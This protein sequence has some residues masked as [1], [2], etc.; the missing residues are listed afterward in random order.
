VGRRKKNAED[1]AGY[2][3]ESL[4]KIDEGHWEAK[5]RFVGVRA[6]GP[7]IYGSCVD[8]SIRMVIPGKRNRKEAQEY[9]KAFLDRRRWVN[10][11]NNQMVDRQ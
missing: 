5:L 8:H 7:G 11:F 10:G 6:K 2:E 9:V 4:E 3:L 1:P